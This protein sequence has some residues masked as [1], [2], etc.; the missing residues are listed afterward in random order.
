[1]DRI[2]KAK[3]N[4]SENRPQSSDLAAIQAK[5]L[6]LLSTGH[7]ELHPH[8]A[9]QGSLSPHERL[10]IYASAYRIRLTQVIE[11]DHCQLGKYLGD[12][13]FALMVEGYLAA[14]PS[15]YT[16][17][18]Y[19]ADKLP[20]FL[21]RTAP[22][23]EHQILAEMAHFERCLLAAFDAK[24][25]AYLNSETLDAVP[26]QN[27]PQLV[28]PLHPSVQLVSYQTSA[29]E[30]WQALKND[31][32]PPPADSANDVMEELGVT[33]YWV[34]WRSF[35]RV[36]EYRSLSSEEFNLLSLLADQHGFDH[37]CHRLMQHHPGAALVTVLRDYIN[38]WLSRGLL[39]VL[40]V[41]DYA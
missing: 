28:L 2:D 12:N 6:A 16:S 20:E 4:V 21:S 9:H 29:V 27:W 10:S 32:P 1:M 30:S 40:V 23:A 24:D 35:E 14:H 11:Q 25:T 33:R 5:F 15:S 18:R 26:A 38:T 31:N 3:D 34:I 7:D 36:T 37:L 41:S 19:F 39:S 13:G 22:F 17:L 8:I